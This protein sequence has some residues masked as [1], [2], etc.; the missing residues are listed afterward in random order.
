MDFNMEG[1]KGNCFVCVQMLSSSSKCFEIVMF[2]PF[3]SQFGSSSL[4]SWRVLSRTH[5]K[6]RQ[7][8]GVAMFHSVGW[9][10]LTLGVV[11]HAVLVCC[12][13]DTVQPLGIDTSEVGQTFYGIG[14]LSGGGAIAEFRAVALNPIFRLRATKP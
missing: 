6:Q 2:A 11:L 5:S 10:W 13:A 4:G 12:I 8:L 9:S 3:R 7:Q 14:G 1:P